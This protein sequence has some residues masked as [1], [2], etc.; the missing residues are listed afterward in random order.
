[1]ADLTG[2]LR[3]N[4]G[5]YIYKDPDANIKYAL[6]F[7]N[8]LNNGDTIVDN[9]STSPIVTIGTITGDAAPLTHPTSHTR[10]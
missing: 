5:I 7:T 6:D 1:M 10:S 8:Y 9:G 3:D 4:K 2:Y